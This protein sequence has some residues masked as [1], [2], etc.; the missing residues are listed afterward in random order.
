MTTEARF[1]QRP[2]EV[3]AH[4]EP[5]FFGRLCMTDRYAWIVTFPDNTVKVYKPEEFERE[6]EPITEGKEK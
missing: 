3:T 1:R 4:Q 2:V 6:F 5:G